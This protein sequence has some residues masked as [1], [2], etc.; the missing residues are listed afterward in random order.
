M[1]GSYSS[2]DHV[3]GGAV[4]FGGNVTGFDRTKL[5]T[6]SGREY[7]IVPT[8]W[9]VHDALQTPLPSSGS[10]DDLLLIGGAHGTNTPLIK[11]YD[12]KA[13]GALTLYART[14]F[15]LPP[16]YV[17]AG[18][19]FIRTRAKMET[20]VAD[21]TATI[22]FTIYKSN[23]EGGLGSDLVSTVAQDINSLSYANQTFTLSTGTLLPGNLLDIRMAVAI[24]D[25]ATATA[26]IAAI[27]AV[28][29]LL[30]I[31]G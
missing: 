23:E 29:M 2:E 25:A 26:V 21:V 4:H 18:E 15:R 28:K 8:D 19:A 31:R 22:D 6:D 17:A 5:A 10:A 7:P 24:N 14:L 11:S 30:N 20:T 9:R 12:V 1:P 13:L 16:E 3:F 27:G